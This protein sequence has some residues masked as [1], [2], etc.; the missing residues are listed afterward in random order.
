MTA[1]RSS[2]P[3]GKGSRCR[4]RWRLRGHQ[5]PRDRPAIDIQ[6][7]RRRSSWKLPEPDD[8][9]A[10]ADLARGTGAPAREFVACN[11]AVQPEQ[12]I[13]VDQALEAV[14]VAAGAERTSCLVAGCSS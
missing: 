12:K 14:R 11:F 6:P 9:R 3:S 13:V 1:L 2:Q 7:E 10:A 8:P 4:T 5:R